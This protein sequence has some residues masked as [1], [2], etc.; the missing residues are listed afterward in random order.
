MLTQEMITWVEVLPLSSS[1]Q[2][3]CALSPILTLLQLTAVLT[4]VTTDSLPWS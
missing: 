1:Q 2:A 3:P 4:K